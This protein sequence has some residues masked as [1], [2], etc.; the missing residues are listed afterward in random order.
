MQ[1]QGKS[2]SNGRF[3]CA[4]AAFCVMAAIASSAQTFTTLINFNVTTG[5]FPSPLVQG[6]DGELYGT[7]WTYGANGSGTA[8]KTTLQGAL[9]TLHN[10]CSETNCADGMLPSGIPLTLGKNGSLYGGTLTWGANNA[11]TLFSMTESGQLTT[12][13]NLGQANG[14]A[15][16][17]S[18]LQLNDGSFYATST[19]G[20]VAC[21]INGASGC[22]T[23]FK[24]SPTGVVTTVYAFCSHQQKGGNCPDGA[25]PAN[26]ILGLNGYLYG[27]TEYGG[28]FNG[29]TIFQVTPSGQFSTL[30]SFCAQT[31]CADGAG[32]TSLFQASDG[33]L[34]GT[35]G[36]GTNNYGT[37]FR[38]TVT[39]T[40]TTLYSF[41]SVT[42]CNDGY[43][44]EFLMEASD[45]NL[46][47]TT[48]GGGTDL[49][50]TI[51]QL[52]MSGNLTTLHSFVV[53]DGAQPIGIIQD[54][55]GNFYGA[56]T[57]GGSSDV[58]TFFRLSTGL[59]PFVKF[60]RG[61]GKVGQSGGI[62][63]QG[64]TGTIGVFLN[65]TPANFTV[66]SDTY[67]QATVPLGGTSGYVTV[68]TPSGTLNSNVPFQVIP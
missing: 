65:G 51:F 45:G 20:G 1:D 60:V 3:F 6:F 46:Y 12:L 57:N 68:N 44:P 28:R 67:I 63:G 21:Q 33:N 50:G 4:V 62:L 7:T 27:T 19:W 34:Y 64:F 14:P 48:Y 43:Q 10:F 13:Y 16:R 49:E 9:T 66:V 53:T 18:L 23:L 2:I 52:T 40:L 17:V 35:S 41:C 56:T 25:F 39:G 8:F 55:D 59:G 61:Y 37:I 30:Y 31:D 11:G 58:G 15:S 24:T 32:P 47:G 22:G 5:G 36:G 29:G 54:T 38:L 42:G 26:L